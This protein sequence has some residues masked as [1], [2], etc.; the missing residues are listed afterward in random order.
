MDRH[1]RDFGITRAQ[2]LDL[3]G[4]IDGKNTK[5]ALPPGADTKILIV[6]AKGPP[7][8][9][10]REFGRDGGGDDDIARSAITLAH[11]R[12]AKNSFITVETH[13]LGQYAI[14]GK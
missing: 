14:N 8:V 12:C 9:D 5:P 10:S 3:T 11:G 6:F 13:R 1:E 2:N 7:I 4:M